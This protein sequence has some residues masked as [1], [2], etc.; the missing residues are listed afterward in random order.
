MTSNPP[1]SFTSRYEAPSGPQAPWPASWEPQ[2]EPLPEPQPEPVTTAPT[3]PSNRASSPP[4]TGFRRDAALPPAAP[5][6]FARWLDQEERDLVHPR[7]VE[8]KLRQAGWHPAQAA[9][10]AAR[11]RLRFD[12]HRLGYSA[13]LVSTGIAALAG[14]SVGHQ[15]AAGI[16]QAINRN[17]L[18]AWLTILVV[19]LPFAIWAHVWAAGVDRDDPVAVW[20]APRRT[21]ALALVWSCGVVGVWRLL[22]YAAQL[23]GSLVHASWAAGES[24][25]AGAVNVAITVGIALPLGLWAFHFL[26]RFDGE[27]PTRPERRR[28]IAGTN[29]HR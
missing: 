23:V 15:L 12:E 11:Y 29:G 2:P 25:G 26:H 20:S 14:G 10:E 18:G 19:S 21:L 9:M 7:V 3:P 24:V 22:R 13:L 27:D 4:P 8:N 28:R 1:T 5:G 6:E 16:D 17:L